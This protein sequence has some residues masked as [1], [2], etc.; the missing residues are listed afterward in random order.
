MEAWRLCYFHN[1]G[2]MGFFKKNLKRAVSVL[3]PPLVT[4][5]SEVVRARVFSPMPLIPPPYPVGLRSGS[6]TRGFVIVG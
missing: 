4:V 5:S 1:E 6:P 2:K 3:V